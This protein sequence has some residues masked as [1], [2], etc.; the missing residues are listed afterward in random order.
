VI[1]EAKEHSISRRL[2]EDWIPLKEVNKSGEKES[3]FIRAPK[4][5]NLHPWSARR[6]CGV[7]RALTAACILPSTDEAMKSFGEIIGLTEVENVPYGLIYLTEPD[8]ETLAKSIREFSGRSL[9]DVIVVDP[10]AG[11]GTVI[12]VCAVLDRKCLAYDIK[13]PEWRGDIVRND[14]RKMPLDN[15]SADMVFLHPPY[16]NM[17]YYTRFKEKL[18]DLSRAETLEKYLTMLKEVLQEAHRI[19][20]DGRFLCVLIGDRIKDGRFIA[21]C[22]K[23]ANLAEEVGFTDCG[24]AVKFTQGATSL[25]EKGKIIYAEVAHTKNLKIEHDLVMF[26]R[27]EP[28]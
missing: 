9:T 6:P 5:N 16:W 17:V 12:D 14:S 20:K 7:A 25:K 24:Y 23:V 27:K 28:L 26:F 1:N 22:R 21:L 19:L 13:P 10:M 3:G 18:S 11:S 4:I 8:R 2:I 15:N